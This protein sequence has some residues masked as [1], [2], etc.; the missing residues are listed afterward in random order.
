M[1]LPIPLVLE[2]LWGLIPFAFYIPMIVARIINE[3]KVLSLELDG[4]AEYKKKIK[5]RLI[6]FVW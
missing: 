1:F 5:Y 4:Y 2:S 6:P 3:E